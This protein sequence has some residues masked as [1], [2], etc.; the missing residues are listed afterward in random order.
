MSVPEALSI[1]GQCIDLKVVHVP[2][3]CRPRQRGCVPF[4]DHPQNSTRWK[5]P[6]ECFFLRL[7]ADTFGHAWRAL[8]TWIFCLNLTLL[9]CNND[10]KYTLYKS[11]RSKTDR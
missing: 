3:K 11:T 9:I 5:S 8:S 1:E 2:D 10:K 4:W 7:K 6:G